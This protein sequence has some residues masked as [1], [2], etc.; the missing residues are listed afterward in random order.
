MCVCIYKYIYIY[1]CAGNLVR[2]QV[3]TDFNFLD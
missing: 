1:I 3:A 2:I